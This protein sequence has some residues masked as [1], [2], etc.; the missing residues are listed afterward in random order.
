MGAEQGG[1]GG[2]GGAGNGA[3]VNGKNNDEA[4]L[5]SERNAKN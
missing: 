3:G 4:N 5:P 1:T 2:K